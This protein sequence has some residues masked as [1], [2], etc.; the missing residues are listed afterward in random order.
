[1]S[2][3]FQ[4]YTDPVNGYIFRSL[5]DIDRYLLSGKLGKHV[6]KNKLKNINSGNER[7]DFAQPT[8]STCIIIKD[9]SETTSCNIL[10]AFNPRTTPRRGIRALGH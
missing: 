6:T 4:Y 7:L 8:V 5:K 9:Q 1:M 3:H 10:R 2:S